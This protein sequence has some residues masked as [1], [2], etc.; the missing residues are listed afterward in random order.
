MVRSSI[1]WLMRPMVWFGSCAITLLR[2]VPT[3]GSSWVVLLWRAQARLMRKLPVV[4]PFIPTCYQ[5]GPRLSVFLCRW[6]VIIS[7]NGMRWLDTRRLPLH[8][9]RLEC[10]VLMLESQILHLVVIWLR[11]PM[12]VARFTPCLVDPDLPVV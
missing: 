3:S 9:R 2:L 6:P 12:V 7:L 4:E 8:N 11:V 1:T 10:G 5:M